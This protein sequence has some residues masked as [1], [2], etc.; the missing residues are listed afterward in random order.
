MK[1][2][3]SSSL[4]KCRRKKPGSSNGC[5]TF[6]GLTTH[7]TLIA[8]AALTLPFLRSIEIRRTRCRPGPAAASS[9]GGSGRKFGL[10]GGWMIS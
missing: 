4:K 5:V 6:E 10:A 8:R 3:V 2:W 9:P 1:T 7:R